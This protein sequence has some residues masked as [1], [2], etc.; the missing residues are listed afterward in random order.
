LK[1]QDAIADALATGELPGTWD[2]PVMDA[3]KSQVAERYEG[4]NNPCVGPC[5]PE[6]TILSY[7]VATDPILTSKPDIRTLDQKFGDKGQAIPTIF[8]F[9]R[10]RDDGWLEF[11]CVFSFYYVVRFD[12]TYSLVCVAS[13]EREERF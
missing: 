5:W 4:E 6:I 10:I 9:S 2:I 1:A 3:L 8:F 12:I 11:T 13:V 7:D